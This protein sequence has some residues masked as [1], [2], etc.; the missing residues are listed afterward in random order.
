MGC[1]L[2]ARYCGGNGI[3]VWKERDRVITHVHR[4]GVWQRKG[5]TSSLEFLHHEKSWPGSWHHQKGVNQQGLQNHPH[6]AS[7]AQQQPSPSQ[8]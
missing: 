4:E 7:F 8:N 5:G 2:G 3:F 1:L 6:A